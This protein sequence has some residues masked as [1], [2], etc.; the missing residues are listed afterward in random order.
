[1]FGYMTD[2]DK[3]EESQSQTVKARGKDLLWHLPHEY[4]RRLVFMKC[5]VVFGIVEDFILSVSGPIS[6]RMMNDMTTTPP[7]LGY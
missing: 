1:M 4:Q 7:S 5:P 3:V 2:L 6:P